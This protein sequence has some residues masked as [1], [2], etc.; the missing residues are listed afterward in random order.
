[1]IITPLL[2]KLL[3]QVVKRWVYMDELMIHGG[4][5]DGVNFPYCWCFIFSVRVFQHLPALHLTLCETLSIIDVKAT[6]YLSVML[7]MFSLESNK[8]V[9]GPW[10]TDY[11]SSGTHDSPV[12]IETSCPSLQR[13]A[14]WNLLL[15][16]SSCVW[17]LILCISKAVFL[18][19]ASHSRIQSLECLFLRRKIVD[20]D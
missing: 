15:L 3:L 10:L 9:L 7:R 8:G 14:E 20:C 6:P 18:K 5:N 16:L 19:F 4:T 2:F 11:T 17:K 1:M 13:A 12:C